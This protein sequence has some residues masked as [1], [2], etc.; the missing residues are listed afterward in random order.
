[1]F[2]HASASELRRYWHPANDA[3][4]ER[5]FHLR[6]YPVPGRSFPHIQGRIAKNS[7]ASN[8]MRR[9]AS[10]RTEIISHPLD[11]LDRG[12]RTVENTARLSVRGNSGDH[13]PLSGQCLLRL[14]GLREPT[15]PRS[16]SIAAAHHSGASPLVGVAEHEPAPAGVDRVLGI[17]GDEGCPRLLQ[18]YRPLNQPPTLGISL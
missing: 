13:P 2:R 8:V 11:M 5:T 14:E 17:A 18:P 15:R 3:Y 1:M 9:P 12:Q 6:F 10:V 4:A 7:R 16:T